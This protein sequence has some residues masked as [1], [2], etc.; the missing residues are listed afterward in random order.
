KPWTFKP[1]SNAGK[2]E[3]FYHGT[4]IGDV[5]GD[6]R[7]DLLLNE[8]W[9][10]QPAD[11]SAEW[12][13]H[14]F[15]FGEKGGAQMFAYD[16]NGD[17]KNDIITSLDAH[18]WGLAWFE[19]VKMGPE[20]TFKEHKLMG[21]RSEETRYGVCFSQPHALAMADL[22]GDGLLDIIVGKR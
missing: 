17:G 22:D 7:N 18:G 10:E 6:G 14:E 13:R 1:I 21:D 16:V 3:Q 12:I 20:I 2:W 5:N 15:K 19:N 4:G 9:Y 8:G 11:R